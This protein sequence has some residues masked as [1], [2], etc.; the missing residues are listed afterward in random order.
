MKKVIIAAIKNIDIVGVI[1]MMIMLY[2]AVLWICNE[3]IHWCM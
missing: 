2:Y 1:V 3:W